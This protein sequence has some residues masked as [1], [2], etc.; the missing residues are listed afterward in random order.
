MT[1]PTTLRA[2]LKVLRNAR[3]TDEMLAAA[4]KADGESW[5]PHRAREAART[6]L[7]SAISTRWPTLA[8]SPALSIKGCDFE[9]A[10]RRGAM[11]RPGRPPDTAESFVKNPE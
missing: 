4:I 9:A 8:Q 1:L 2:I 10:W 6:T 5:T 3:A 7:A 11:S